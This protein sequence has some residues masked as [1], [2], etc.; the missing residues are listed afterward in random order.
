MLEILGSLYGFILHIK[1][2]QVQE[3]MNV[4]TFRKLVQKFEWV[5]EKGFISN[6]LCVIKNVASYWSKSIFKKHD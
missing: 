2:H 6:T 4:F 5:K 1:S 3:F